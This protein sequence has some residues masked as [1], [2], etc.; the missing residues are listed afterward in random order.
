[1]ATRQ[2]SLNAFGF[3][4][5]EAVQYAQR[6]AGHVHEIEQ[7]LAEIGHRVGIRQLELLCWRERNSKRETRVIGILS[8]IHTVV[9]KSLFGK[10][11]DGLERSTDSADSYLIHDN[12]PIIAGFVSVPRQMGD[13]NCNAFTAGVIEAV[14]ERSQFPA[15]VS[16]HNGATSNFPRR[17][18]FLIKFDQSV[19]DRD[20]RLEASK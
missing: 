15:K 2:I 5:S 20:R 10:Q 7:L 9:F 4:F 13:F 6:R 19:M 14:L 18:T 11:S 16:A 12:D 8:F 3:L 1:M 17:T